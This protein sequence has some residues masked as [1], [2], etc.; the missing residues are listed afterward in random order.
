MNKAF[1]EVIVTRTAEEEGCR[2]IQSAASSET[3]FTAGEKTSNWEI[4]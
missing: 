4:I 1:R 3:V 2:I